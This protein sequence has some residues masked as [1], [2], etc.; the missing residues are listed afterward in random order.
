MK[1]RKV[2]HKKIPAKQ[3]ALGIAY[4]DAELDPKS[5]LGT[6]EI[7]I[8]QTPLNILDVEIH[9]FIHMHYPE[10]PEAS[11]RQMGTRLAKFLWKLKYRK[12]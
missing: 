2:I 1:I 12:Q 11:V 9:E 10:I 5:K 8:R 6:I 4:N 7:E 3:K